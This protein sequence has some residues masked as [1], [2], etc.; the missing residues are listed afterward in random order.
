MV[1]ERGVRLSGGQ[2]Q[3]VAIARAI[4]QNPRILLLDEATSALDAESEHLVKEAL[5][6]LMIGRTTV[7]VAHRLSTVR[8]ANQVAVIH[9][10][11]VAAVGTHDELLEISPLYAR[12]VRRQL[13]T[14]E[15]MNGRDAPG[16][17]ARGASG[18]TGAAGGRVSAGTTPLH[19]VLSAKEVTAISSLPEPG[20]AFDLELDGSKATPSGNANEDEGDSGGISGSKQKKAKNSK[21]G[22]T[23]SEHTYITVSGAASAAG[24][25]SLLQLQPTPSPSPLSPPTTSAMDYNAARDLDSRRG[26]HHVSLSVDEDSVDEYR[27]GLRSGHGVNESK[28]DESSGAHSSSSAGH[29]PSRGSIGTRGRRNPLIAIASGAS[30]AGV[31]AGSFEAHE[32]DVAASPSEAT[33]TGSAAD[34]DADEDLREDE[35]E[36]TGLLH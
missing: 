20:D 2:K 11:A 28:F 30:A 15:H 32:R 23:A 10:G 26:H 1:G 13:L 29:G 21:G 8:Q 35:G 6:K 27:L 17:R 36:L 34:A 5:D 25:G 31:D 19:V 33:S 12:L 4:L 14:A 7:I 22:G 9:R 18:E 24:V 16:S 3:R